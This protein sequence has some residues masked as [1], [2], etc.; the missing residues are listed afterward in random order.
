MRRSPVTIGDIANLVGCS[1]GTVSLAL[2]DRPGVSGA[3]RGRVLKV[4]EALGYRPN[5]I[6]RRLFS[7]ETR[8]IGVLFHD[9]S[10]FFMAQILQGINDVAA[11]RGYSVILSLSDRRFDR[12]C[13]LLELLVSEQVDGIVLCTNAP[14]EGGEHLRELEQKHVPLVLVD[15]FL[16]GTDADYVVSDNEAG[17]YQL[18]RYL[19]ESGHRRIGM[20]VT[21]EPISPIRQ[22]VAGY[23]R[24]LEEFDISVDDLLIKGVD[25]FSQQGVTQNIESLNQALDELMG[26]VSPP[27]CLVTMSSDLTV[28]TLGWLMHRGIKVPQEMVL[29]AFDQVPLLSSLG[30][31]LT[32]VAQAPFAMG[33]R[34]AQLLLERIAGNEEV[35]G[36]IKLPLEL[37]RC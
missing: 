30:K 11:A 5:L 22:R 27:S 34:A 7:K 25:I 21:D 4:A 6:A 36:K 14:L 20:I 16:T 8:I 10:G 37:I 32:T 2:N 26:L 1:R 18:V 3:T 31:Q 17:A 15:R 28:E 12:E 13:E 33:T 19:I 29:A 35:E 23:R 9:I 24:A